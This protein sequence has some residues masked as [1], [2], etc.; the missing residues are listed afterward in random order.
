M[1][2]TTRREAVFSA[3]RSP[4]AALGG[5][6]LA[7]ILV[8]API[9]QHALVGFDD[10]RT[11]ERIRDGL[12]LRGVGWAFTSLEM[13]NWHPLTWLSLQLD[14]ALFGTG[15]QG[16]HITN[17]ILHLLTTAALFGALQSLTRRPWSS[18]VVAAGFALH[19]LHV[20]SVAWMAERKDVLSGLFFALML[21][22]Y[23]RYAERETAPRYAAVAI[24]LSCGLMAKA[25]L[26]TAPAVLLL[27]D[28][29]PLRRWRKA[30]WR[31][32]ALEKVPLLVLCS[33]AAIVALI[34]QS[35][36]AMPDL[37]ALPLFERFLNAG[38]SY[39]AYLRDTVLPVDLA[40]YYPHPGAGVPLLPGL[41][42]ALA[43][44]GA[45]T[46]LWVQRRRYPAAL[47]GWLWFLGMLLPVI[48][49][50]QVG[51]QARADR[52]MYLPLAGV[53]VAL[54]WTARAVAER[55]HV[56]RQVL[57]PAAAASLALLGILSSEQV[58]HWRNSDTL[59]RH[60]LAVTGPNAR[61]HHL[62]GWDLANRSRLSEAIAHYSQA[63]DIDPGYHLV[64][65]RRAQALAVSGQLDA[66]ERDLRML[67]QVDPANA[68]VQRWLVS[69]DAHRV[70]PRVVVS[71]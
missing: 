9:A 58:G 21:W 42:A 2:E 44:L 19:P 63:L 55:F 65:L 48:G 66:A 5:V 54:V 51:G 35:R 40:I 68:D 53:L 25:M 1:W 8:Y 70:A 6:L 17:L 52:Y 4:Y 11:L 39:C 32:C 71:E 3:L 57:V 30:G 37:H 15:P 43:I 46:G 28:F 49:L 27:L 16:F 18:L 34:A 64:R 14:V 22:A 13:S 38:L 24:T 41:L 36:T 31:R 56:R 7:T 69:V 23:A 26:V 29:W 10:G 45:S 59:F 33:G 12:S 61:I 50:V 20:E 60:A 67:L 62:L 47:T